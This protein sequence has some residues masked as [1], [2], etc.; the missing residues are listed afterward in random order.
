MRRLLTVV[1]LLG[2]PGAFAQKLNP[3]QWS[4]AAGSLSAAPGSI[5]SARIVAKLDPGWHIYSLTTPEGGP[6]PTTLKLEPNPAVPSAKFYQPK[7]HSKFDANFKIDTEIYEGEVAF[8]AQFTI[9]EN[10]KPGP[11]DAAITARYQ[12]CTE[13]ECLP[14]KAALTAQWTIDP[15]A[16]T[17]ALVVPAGYDEFTGKRSVAASSSAPPGRSAADEGLASFLLI[18]FG[19]GLAAI[20]TPCVFPM[21]PITLSFFLNREGGRADSL[22]QAALF[23]VGIVVL[24]TIIG[25]SVAA[26]LGPFGVVQLGSN[27]WVN[28]FITAVFLVFGISLLGAFEITLPSSLLTKMDKAS[29]RGGIGGTLLMGLTFSLT[30]FAC[31]GPFMGAL[32][33]GSVQRGGIQPALGMMTFA[34]GLASPFFLLALFP[35]YLRRLPKS[36]G[37]LARVKVVLGFII[38]AWALKYLSSIDQVMQWNVLTRE[39]FLAVWFVM[40]LLPGCYLLGWLRMEGVRSDETVG[41]GRTLAGAVFVIFAVSLLP[42]MF[43]A[44]LGELDSFVPLASEAR[45]NAAGGPVAAGW[46]KNDFSAAAARARDEGKLIFVSFTGYA[47]TNCHWMK[48]NMFSRPEIAEALGNYVLVELYTDGTDAVSERNQQLQEQKF[49]TVAIPFYAIMD[50]DQR[51]VSTFAGLTRKAPEY[52]TFLRTGAAQTAAR[53]Q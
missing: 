50:T 16:K 9:A 5:A 40:F 41:V 2:A 42:G 37:W 31:V 23:C 48:A 30:S 21:I 6:T 44:R 34:A 39:R 8:V 14:R 7:P 49:G 15:K 45:E 46:I 47:C 1:L 10:L 13:K 51:V 52:L 27:V 25:L 53:V 28:A 29:Q 33:A 4:V 26:I 22:R 36:G 43:G 32:L 18:A 11:L 38:L 19:F 17:T 3:V 24:F 12:A 20:F 35:S